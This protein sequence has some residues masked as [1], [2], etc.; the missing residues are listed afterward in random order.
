ML[1]DIIV[2]DTDIDTPENTGHTRDMEDMTRC[3]AYTKTRTNARCSACRIYMLKLDYGAD[4]LVHIL[5]VF[6]PW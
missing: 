2:A 5:V 1:F 3:A 6:C 4:N